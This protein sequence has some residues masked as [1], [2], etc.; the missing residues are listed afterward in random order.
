MFN[1]PDSLYRLENITL[2]VRDVM[3]LQKLQV[4][5]LK[6]LSAMMRGL[7]TNIF[8]DAIQMRMGHGKCPVAFL[9]GKMT[10]DPSP[11]VDVIRRPGLEIA[12]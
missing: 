8:D 2:I 11:L 9:P 7:T 6:R 3:S 4:F 10:P 12:N 5:A 1:V